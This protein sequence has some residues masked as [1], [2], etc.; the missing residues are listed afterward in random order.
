[1]THNLLLN[2]GLY[3]RMEIYVSSGTQHLTADAQTSVVKK[4]K[5]LTSFLKNKKNLFSEATQ[6]Q[7]GRDDQVPQ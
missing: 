5:Y 6:S 4:T 1:M 7:R 2:Y 3:R